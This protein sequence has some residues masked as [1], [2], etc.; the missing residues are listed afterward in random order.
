MA[1]AQRAQLHGAV[2]WLCQLDAVCIYICYFIPVLGAAFFQAPN[3]LVHIGLG[4]RAQHL[5]GQIVRCR[6]PACTRH[7]VHKPCHCPARIARIIY[8]VAVSIPHAIGGHALVD[9]FQRFRTLF[10]II[11]KAGRQRLP[12]DCRSSRGKARRLLH[13]RAGI[14]VKH[15]RGIVASGL[16][17][18]AGNR[19]LPL[20]AAAV[21]VLQHL[22]PV[23]TGLAVPHAV[24][25]AFNVLAAAGCRKFRIVVVDLLKVSHGQRQAAKTAH[26]VN[27]LQGRSVDLVQDNRLCGVIHA[28]LQVAVVFHRIVF[29]AALRHILSQVFV[30]AGGRVVIRYI[31]GLI[32]PQLHG[33]FVVFLA[34]KIPEIPL[35][36]LYPLVLIVAHAVYHLGHD[37]IGSRR[38]AYIKSHIVA[39]PLC[40]LG[41]PLA[42]FFCIR[43]HKSTVQHAV[44]VVRIH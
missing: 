9:L 20:S 13:G 28:V 24:H 43:D 27:A 37:L 29:L 10:V 6:D 22:F 25:N 18:K 14:A 32:S 7:S 30:V 4:C 15:G 34:G 19:I 35:R 2:V 40:L 31:C 16:R 41:I 33:R 1:A 36:G 38:V 12:S 26:G 23:D 42:Q 11:R 17:K 8:A 39:Q 44:T 3:V 5:N 21:H